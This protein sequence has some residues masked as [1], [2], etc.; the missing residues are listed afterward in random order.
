MK[1]YQVITCNTCN[2]QFAACFSQHVDQEWEREVFKYIKY[3]K[4]RIED[5]DKLEL[6]KPLS[7]CC[8][9]VYPKAE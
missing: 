3:G 1:N 4:A 2:T 9:D 6:D 8:G 5:V 7:G